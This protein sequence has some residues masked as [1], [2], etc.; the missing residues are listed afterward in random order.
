[1]SKISFLLLHLGYGG[2][3]SSTINTANALSDKYEI[4]LVVFY[5]LTRNQENKLN[6]NI[7][8]RYMYDGGPNKEQF[9]SCI[10]NKKFFSMI[11]EGFKSLDILIKKKL[12]IIKY[13]KNCDSKYIVSTRIEFSELLNKY[14]KNNTVK[15][16]QEHHHHN[17]DKKYIKRLKNNYNRIDYLCALTTTLKK[18][19][20]NFLSNNNHTKIILM[21]NMLSDL[22]TKKTDLKNK[23]FIS[24]SRLDEGKKIDEIIKIFSK[25]DNRNSNLYVI[26][27]GKEFNNLQLLVKEL[28]LSKKVHLLGYLD[29]KEIEKYMLKSSV[30]LMTS[31]SE[32]LPM[33]L[34][35]AMSYGL[36]CIAYETDSGTTDIIDDGKNGYIIK[37]R[38]EDEYIEKVNN[39]VNDSKMLKEFSNSSMKKSKKFSSVE[40]LKIWYKILK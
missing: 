14:G 4:E 21:P 6:K 22:P 31:V 11:K 13:I 19:Y 8:I 26:G 1:M 15:I 25:V 27:D 12:L 38:N 35:E 7:K 3:E 16:A 9:L 17:N 23:N 33:V 37:N 28:K 40:I 29:K 10:K 5:N 39:L 30:F 24:V 36:P 18:D 32:G 34:L 2:I 20:E